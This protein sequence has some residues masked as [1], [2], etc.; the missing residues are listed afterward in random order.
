MA[1]LKG[2]RRLKDLSYCLGNGQ[3]GWGQE[4]P[5]DDLDLL[6][7]GGQDRELFQPPHLWTLG[8]EVTP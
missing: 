5:P 2:E 6:R 1:G 3:R 4:L 7:G 8:L